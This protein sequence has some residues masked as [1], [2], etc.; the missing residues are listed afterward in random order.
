MKGD[1]GHGYRSQ[2]PLSVDQRLFLLGRELVGRLQHA[3]FDRDLDDVPH[4]LLGL[5]LVIG[6]ENA[7]VMVQ[8]STLVAC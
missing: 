7:S 6:L 1:E 8:Q 3:N 5:L 4:H 2:I